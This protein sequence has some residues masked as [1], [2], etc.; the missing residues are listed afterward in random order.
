MHNNIWHTLVHKNIFHALRLMNKKEFYMLI[1]AW[2]HLRYFKIK[3]WNMN[4][5]RFSEENASVCA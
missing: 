3:A 1:S 5:C 4:I 2:K